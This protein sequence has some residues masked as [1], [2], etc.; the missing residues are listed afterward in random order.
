MKL[1]ERTLYL[2][3]LKRVR[4]TPDIKIITGIRRSG[5]SEL[6]RS[7]LTYL[8]ETE[9]ETNIIEIDYGNLKYDDSFLIFLYLWLI[10]LMKWL[11]WL[12]R[13]IDFAV[14]WK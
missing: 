2:D 12:K 13:N 8:K 7:S 1:I 11:K 4:N 14:S 3:R 9:P 6:M 10:T 5:K